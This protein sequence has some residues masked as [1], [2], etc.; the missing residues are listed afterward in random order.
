MSQYFYNSTQYLKTIPLN[1]KELNEENEI[2][3]EKCLKKIE[4]PFCIDGFCSMCS[5][6]K[7]LE[8]KIKLDKFPKIIILVFMAMKIMQNI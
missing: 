7:M 6:K 5:S 8:V 2:D 4:N 1:I 3:L